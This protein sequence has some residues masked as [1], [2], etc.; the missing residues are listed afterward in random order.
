MTYASIRNHL[1]RFSMIFIILVI[2]SMSI[3]AAYSENNSKTEDT[4]LIETTDNFQT[5]GNNN[6]DLILKG[7]N[8]KTIIAPEEYNN[9][10]IQDTAKLTIQ[11]SE[12]E[13]KGLVR[14]TD[15]AQLIIK[16]SILKISPPNLPDDVMV[17]TICG[18]A[19]VSIIDSTLIT[20]SQPA[21]T[22]VTYLITD[23]NS[24]ITI[25]NSK[26]IAYLPSVVHQ[27]VYLTPATAGV[28]VITGESTWT[29]TDSE[30]EGHLSYNES[31]Y[32]TGRWFWITQQRKANVKIINTICT[33]NEEGQPFFKP[34]SGYMELKNVEITLGMIDAEVIA[35]LKVFNLTVSYFNVRDQARAVVENSFIKND[36]DVG[37]AAIISPTEGSAQA[38]HTEARLDIRN[39]S[40]GNAIM[41]SGNSTVDTF[42]CEFL[43]CYINNNATVKLKS[44]VAHRVTLHNQGQLYIESSSI[45]NIFTE[46]QSTATIMNAIGK[47]KWIRTGYNC[48]SS[49]TI[50]NS[51]IDDF[52]VWPGDN[53]GPITTNPVKYGAG[54]K[55]DL[56]RSQIHL[57]MVNSAIENFTIYDDEIIVIELID[58]SI[59]NFSIREFKYE[60]ISLTFID[61]NSN[62]PIPE[63]PANQDAII[64]IQYK[65]ELYT[66][67]NDMPVMASIEILDKNNELLIMQSTNDSGR[68]VFNLN[69]KIIDNSGTE[70]TE[71]YAYKISYFGISKEYDLTLKASQVQFINLTDLS[72]PTISDLK[73]GPTAWNFEKE[74]KIKAVVKDDDIK[75]I[76]NVTLFYS[77]NNGKTWKTK[78]M[79]EVE[80]GQ[81]EA[82]IPKQEW[83]TDVEFYILAYDILGNKAESDVKSYSVAEEEINVLVIFIVGMVILIL[84]VIIKAVIQTRKIKKYKK[85]KLSD[86]YKGVK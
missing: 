2:F 33:L 79:H 81:F 47:V 51:D 45:S 5:R 61:V 1:T 54:Y 29:V 12:L 80:E 28:Y 7:T 67:L 42:N 40:I 38:I 72:P 85:R 68:A 77:T 30:L 21:P 17:V 75:L 32:L 9:L 62:Y 31:D 36:I 3:S 35:D 65:F 82:K 78:L 15:N 18:Q 50:I 69:S 24:N 37:S 58:S 83:G 26:V 39:S 44:T 8:Q 74:V 43:S 86:T 13:I 57:K 16:N 56:N 55:R 64:F 19:S 25:E 76:S 53:I 10:S 14:I 34:I 6:I 48:F 27:S 23:D 60:D 11:N 70:T 84:I 73:F 59:I 71:N 41:V 66:M 20:Y 4:N 63:L 49:I 22:N 52:D 46:D